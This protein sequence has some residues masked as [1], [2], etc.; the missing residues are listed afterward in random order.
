MSVLIVAKPYNSLAVVGL[1]AFA[2]ELPPD[3][4]INPSFGPDRI[5]SP[6]TKLSAAAVDHA[7]AE[8]PGALA[9]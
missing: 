8:L 1:L 9:G 3:S 2:D 4:N 6:G 5:V 7:R